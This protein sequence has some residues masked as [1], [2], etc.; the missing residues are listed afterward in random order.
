M[1]DSF[2]NSHIGAILRY[3]NDNHYYKVVLDQNGIHFLKRIDP[4]HG[5]TIGNQTNFSPLTSTLYTIR[6]RVTGTTLMAK[7]WPASAAEPTGWM[8]T[9]QDNDNTFQT[10]KGGLRPQVN[11]GTT[12]SVTMFQETL[13]TGQ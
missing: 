10:G 8:I 11:H 13:P 12:L 2:N 5:P 4:Q 6:F 1:L 3:M 7:A 9:A